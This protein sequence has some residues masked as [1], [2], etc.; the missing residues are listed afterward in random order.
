MRN[1]WTEETTKTT[2]A[3]CIRQTQCYKRDGKRKKEKADIK[4]EA[5]CVQLAQVPRIIEEVRG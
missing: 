1:V 4:G 3:V 2:I 5:E